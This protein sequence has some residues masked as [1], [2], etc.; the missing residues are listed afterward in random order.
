MR[1]F[2]GNLSLVKKCFYTVLSWIYSGRQVPEYWGGQN[3]QLQR[4]VHNPNLLEQN[5]WL[6]GHTM[7]KSM[8]DLNKRGGF[9]YWPLP[10]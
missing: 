1:F 5:N 10:I 8:L 7:A 2:S 9:I 4:N 6:C 3:C